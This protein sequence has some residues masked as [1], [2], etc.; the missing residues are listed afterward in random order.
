MNKL[1]TSYIAGFFKLESAGGILLMLAAALA[2]VLAN[3][4]LQTYYALFIDLPVEVSVG[5]LKIS[6]PLL[7]WINDGLM[8]VFFFLV[9][10]ELKRELVEGELSDELHEKV[11]ALLVELS[12]YN[13]MATLHELAAS[14][15]RQAFKSA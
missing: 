15:A 10:M 2:I 5:A 8:G 6:K 9:G 7:L 3:T 14:R 13:V 11:T 12:A 4:P 1:K